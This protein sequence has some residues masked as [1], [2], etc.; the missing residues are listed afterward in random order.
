MPSGPNTFL[1]YEFACIVEFEP[2]AACAKNAGHPV[3]NS[4]QA[5]C[6]GDCQCK[7]GTT[8]VLNDLV[9]LLVDQ[10]DEGGSDTDVQTARFNIAVAKQENEPGTTQQIILLLEPMFSDKVHKDL[11][12]EYKKKRNIDPTRKETNCDRVSM[13]AGVLR[14][15]LEHLCVWHCDH[16]K[17][18][19]EDKASRKSS[20]HTGGYG[21]HTLGPPKTKIDADA[22]PGKSCSCDHQ[23]DHHSSCYYLEVTVKDVHIRIMPLTDEVWDRRFVNEQSYFHWLKK[24]TN[25]TLNSAS[26][27]LGSAVDTLS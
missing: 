24:T 22:T 15:M 3:G 21:G 20:I 13:E 7:R 1:R 5:R 12:D 26:N 17:D 2:C 19:Y 9:D 23:C 16:C 4:I 10:H 27:T 11:M 6:R 25:T 18:R 8:D 14:N